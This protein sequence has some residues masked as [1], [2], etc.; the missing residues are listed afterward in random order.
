[1]TSG[2]SA[3]RLLIQRPRKT[4]WTILTRISLPLLL[5]IGW[6]LLAKSSLLPPLTLPTPWQVII[7]LK[8]MYLQQHLMF[9]I[10]VS[11]LRA[12]V[13]LSLGAG[14]GFLLGLFSGLSKIGEEFLDATL[15]M[16]RAVPFIALTP[17]FILWFGVGETPKILIVAVATYFPMYISTASGVRNV[18]KKVVEC[19]KTFGLRGP[20]L[21]K[22][23]I[24]PLATPQILTGL[25]LSMVISVLALV[26]GEQISSQNGLGFLFSQSQSY[27]RN[28]EVFT[29]IMLYAC[30]GLLAAV[31]VN[32]LQRILLRWRKG[33]AVR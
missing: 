14:I 17:L 16:F 11:L 33:V 20:R 32:L 7:E 2:L 21:V 22:E 15:Q 25:S 6:T 10:G 24:V 5:L 27:G 26:A 18:D 19:A 23:V 29:C 3:P 8:A 13:G 31:F 4:S 9:N 12:L 28:F 1:M 30:M